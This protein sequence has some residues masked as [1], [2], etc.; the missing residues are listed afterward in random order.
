[1]HTK[2]SVVD[3]GTQTQV[4]ENLATIS[5]NINTPVFPQTLVV[6]AINL[7][8]LTTLVVA[9]NERDTVGVA[10]FEGKEKKKCFDTVKTSIDKIAH[11]EVVCI[12]AFAAHFEE[13]VQVV[14]LSVNV[15]ANLQKPR[16]PNANIGIS[17]GKEKKWKAFGNMRFQ[18]RKGC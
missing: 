11:K 16:R 8:D 2:D 12:G 18:V 14:E 13:F 15:A 10:N 6:E 7:S 3:D 17:G 4:I 9:A 1:M 5:P